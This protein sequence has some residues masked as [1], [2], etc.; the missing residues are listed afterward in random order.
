MVP[1]QEET[2]RVFVF[3]GLVANGDVNDTIKG[4]IWRV[5]SFFLLLVA[6]VKHHLNV[7]I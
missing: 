2:L 7:K 3:S 6:Y 5:D 4:I 1:G